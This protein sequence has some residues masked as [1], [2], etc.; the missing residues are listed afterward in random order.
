MNQALHAHMNNKKK[1]TIF[2]EL[3]V[4]TFARQVLLPLEPLCQLSFLYC[5]CI[6]TLFEAMRLLLIG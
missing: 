2:F 1:K 4:Y 5:Y 6:L 3:R